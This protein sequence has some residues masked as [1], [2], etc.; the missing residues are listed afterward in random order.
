LRRGLEFKEETSMARLT[1]SQFRDL[2]EAELPL[3]RIFGIG[4]EAIGE[5]TARL[6]LEGGDGAARPG[7]TMAGPLLFALADVTLY[8][9]TLSLVGRVPLAVT[10]NVS[11]NFLKK[12]GLGPVIAQGRVLKAGTRLVVGEVSMF[13]KMAGGVSE[14]MPGELVAHAT[15]TYS[16]P[17]TKADK[18]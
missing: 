18:H 15:G 1:L 5:G 6:V 11:I 14:E 3:C 2:I 16:I 7:G 12:P 13:S 17:P 4:V 10:T 8:A 9:V